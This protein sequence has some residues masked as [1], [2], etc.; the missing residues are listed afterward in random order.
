LFSLA[1]VL[2][3]ADLSAPRVGT[4]ARDD[5]VA[6]APKHVSVVYLP[7]SKPWAFES[8]ELLRQFSV[9]KEITFT[10]VHTLPTNDDTLR[11]IGNGEIGGVDLSTEVLKNG[12]AKLKELKRELSEEDNR[13]RELESEARAAGKGIWN[14]HGPKV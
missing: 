2:H 12:W 11:D 7:K 10:S 6:N 5:E 1:R 9:G 3:L 14:S 8:R 13:K 4:S